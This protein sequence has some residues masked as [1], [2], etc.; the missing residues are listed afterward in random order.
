MAVNNRMVLLTS[1]TATNNQDELN[2]AGMLVGELA[3]NTNDGVLFVGQTPV[4]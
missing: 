4:A 2:T 3:V 1:V